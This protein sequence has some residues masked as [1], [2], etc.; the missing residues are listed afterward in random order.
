MAVLAILA[1]PSIAELPNLKMFGI[2][3][4]QVEISVISSKVF[5]LVAEVAEIAPDQ[6]QVLPQAHRR[7]ARE[8]G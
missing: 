1:I 6:A 5:Q 2:S 7:V 3:D 8:S 4:Y